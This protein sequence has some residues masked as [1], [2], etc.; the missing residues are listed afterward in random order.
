M[1]Y[2]TKIRFFCGITRIVGLVIMAEHAILFVL[3]GSYNRVRKNMV[4]PTLLT[5]KE[6]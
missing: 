6:C 1:Y 5:I 2:L 4:L 3:V